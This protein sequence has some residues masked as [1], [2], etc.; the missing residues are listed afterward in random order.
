MENERKDIEVL[1]SAIDDEILR[2]RMKSSMEWYTENAVKN[3]RRFYFLSLLTIIMPLLATLINGWVGVP[4]S[5]IKNLVSLCSMLAA[6]A[7]SSLS[8]LK[9]QEKWILYRSTVE[10]MKSLL[11][12][13]R[14]GEIGKKELSTLIQKL[15]D[16]MD[17]EHLEWR[18]MRSMQR[19]GSTNNE[20]DR[21]NEAP[22]K[23]ADTDEKE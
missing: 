10:R 14:A 19:S 18:E 17:E 20:A 8:L 21:E 1:C 16:C 4:N 11:A 9:C 23:A 5:Y 22:G 6:V 7:A 13:Y 15:E 3:R 2:K 12:L